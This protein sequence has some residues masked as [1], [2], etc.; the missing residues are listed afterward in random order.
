MVLAQLVPDDEMDEFSIPR[1]TRYR[2]SEL[3]V[4]SSVIIARARPGFV[5]PRWPAADGDIGPQ[6]GSCGA[7]L[8]SQRPQRRKCQ[9][10]SLG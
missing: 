5:L 3:P 8:S 6:G 2:D 7:H 10:K 9:T 4:L 1:A